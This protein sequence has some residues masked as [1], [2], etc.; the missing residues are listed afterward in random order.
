MYWWGSRVRLPWGFIP[1]EPTVTDL[2]FP[3]P[4]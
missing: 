4:H 2:D 3:R 1:P